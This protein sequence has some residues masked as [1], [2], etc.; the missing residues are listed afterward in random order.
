MLLQDAVVPGAG[1]LLTSMLVVVVLC[2]G[3][4]VFL[5]RAVVRRHGAEIIGT[6]AAASIFSM[7]ATAKLAAAVGLGGQVARSLLPRAVTAPLALPMSDALGGILPLTAASVCFTG[8]LG[9]AFGQALM[10]RMGL[11]D[12][13]SRGVAQASSAHGLGASALAAT[14]SQALPFSA[15]TIAAMG[16]ISNMLLCVPVLRGA[17]LAITG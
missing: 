8:L 14:E 11:R 5:Q 6:A 2:D 12:E 4:R 17:L 7:F 3:M 15:V 13:I 1:A 16:T 9:A 10:S